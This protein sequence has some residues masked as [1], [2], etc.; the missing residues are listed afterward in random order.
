MTSE[1]NFTKI[2]Y[3][4]NIMAKV[5]HGMSR[6]RLHHIWNGMKQRCSNPN[7]I[8]YK[9]YGAKGVSVCEEWQN[10]TNFCAWALANG[11][12]D[13][14]TLDRKNSS[15]NYEPSNCRWATNKEQQNNTSYNR[16]ITL[17]G[18]THNITQWADII[19][20]PKTT[21][22]NRMR[23]GWDIERALTTKKLR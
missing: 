21:L 14:L 2:I 4:R 22:Y 13:N 17:H 1:K 18:E 6:S 23:R 20:V 7:V 5:I 12:E 15:G 3:R 19:G 8:S 11:Y 10:F 9:Y 16:L